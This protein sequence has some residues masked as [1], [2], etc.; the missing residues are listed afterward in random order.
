MQLADAS[1]IELQNTRT[2]PGTARLSCGS[3][4][5]PLRISATK[6]L[7]QKIFADFLPEIARE[8]GNEEEEQQ[9]HEKQFMWLLRMT[10]QVLGGGIVPGNW[11]IAG[12]VSQG[13][14]QDEA[15][16]FLRDFLRTSVAKSRPWCERFSRT[17][18]FALGLLKMVLFFFF[19]LQS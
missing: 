12:H 5:S 17:L 18:D 19:V 9:F 8:R 16:E 6:Q 3:S 1:L 4:A 7:P 14:Y 2:L 11:V 13:W 15:M 10:S